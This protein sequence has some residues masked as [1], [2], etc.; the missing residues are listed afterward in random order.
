MYNA[1]FKFSESPFENNLDQRLL[2]LCEDHIEVLAAL[3]YFVKEKNG[4][5][6]VCGRH[7][8]DFADQ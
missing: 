8:Q 1:Y 3:L 5:A 2:F 6:L 7:R 4:L